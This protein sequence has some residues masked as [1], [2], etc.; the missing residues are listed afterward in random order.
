MTNAVLH[1]INAGLWNKVSWESSFSLAIMD[2]LISLHIQLIIVSKFSRQFTLTYLSI[3]SIF[4]EH[5][6]PL[7]CKWHCLSICPSP[8]DYTVQLYVH[9]HIDIY[10]CAEFILPAM[11]MKVHTYVQST[12]N[13]L[14]TQCILCWALLRLVSKPIYLYSSRLIPPHYFP[15]TSEVSPSYHG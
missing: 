9:T 15:S 3:A 4:V 14:G 5:D 11:A 2:L 7:C 13:E 6:S 1:R 8:T 10:K 12:S